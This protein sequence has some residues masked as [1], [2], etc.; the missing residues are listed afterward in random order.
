MVGDLEVS[1]DAFVMYIEDSNGYKN[2]VV[3]FDQ[4]SIRILDDPSIRQNPF[5]VSTSLASNTFLLYSDDDASGIYL[6]D[7][8]FK[9]CS[10]YDYSSSECYGTQAEERSVVF[11]QLNSG[12]LVIQSAAYSGDIRFN[13]AG[14]QVGVIQS[15]RDGN[16]NF[17]LT[18]ALG[19]FR[20]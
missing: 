16:T 7:P 15:N 11:E 4:S 18:P 12:E 3:E 6:K 19:S 17:A 5:Y 1:A 10:I 2:S 20:C 13:Q 9:N 8:R 14:Q